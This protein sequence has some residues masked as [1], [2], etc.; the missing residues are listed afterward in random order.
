VVEYTAELEINWPIIIDFNSC[1]CVHM[2][3]LLTGN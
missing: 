2:L 3:T 1:L